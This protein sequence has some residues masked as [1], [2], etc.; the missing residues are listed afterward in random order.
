MLS[1]EYS[2]IRNLLR[3]NL[4]QIRRISAFGAFSGVLYSRVSSTAKL[5]VFYTL[6]HHFQLYSN[7]KIDNPTTLWRANV[8]YPKQLHVIQPHLRILNKAKLKGLMLTIFQLQPRHFLQSSC[9]GPFFQRP[10]RL[11][12]DDHE[13]ENC[14][15]VAMHT[16]C[17]WLVPIVCRRS[18]WNDKDGL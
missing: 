7:F 11:L 13:D 15:N 9:S 4:T 12:D 16:W 2:F 6:K 10:F 1:W 14:I 18:F 17:C 5:C 3:Q 8:F